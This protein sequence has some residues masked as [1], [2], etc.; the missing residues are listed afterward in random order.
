M[1]IDALE[2]RRAIVFA[3]AVLYWT[4]V[5]VQIARVRRR[6]GR[7]PNVKPRGLKERLLWLGW[8][9][10][11]VTWIAQPLALN[12]LDASPPINIIQPLYGL[13]WFIAGVALIICGHAGTYWCYAAMGD[14]WRIGVKKRE[15]TVLVTSGPYAFVRHPIYAFQTMLLFGAA[16]LLPTPLSFAAIAVQLTCAYVKAFDEEAYL[17]ETHADLYSGYLARTGRFLPRLFKAGAP[18]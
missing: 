8:I 13:A 9:A 17:L 14:S 12:R 7:L 6:A 2:A 11:I 5:Y 3:S 16:L 4:S 15:K 10:V 18:K 1:T